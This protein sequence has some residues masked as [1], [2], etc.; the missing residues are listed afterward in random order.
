MWDYN[1]INTCMLAEWCAY[2]F[3]FNDEH[4]SCLQFI[5]IRRVDR[6]RCATLRYA[7][8]RCATLRYAALRCATLRAI[9]SLFRKREMTDDCGRDCIVFTAEVRCIELA[10]SVLCVNRHTDIDQCHCWRNLTYQQS[11]LMHNVGIF[12]ISHYDWTNQP[13]PKRRAREPMRFHVV[14]TW[15]V[16]SNISQHFENTV[17]IHSML[18]IFILSADQN[19]KSHWFP[20]SPFML[21]LIR[22][23]IMTNEE[24]PNVMHQCT[25]LVCQI[26]PTVT[27]IDISMVNRLPCGH[28]N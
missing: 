15:F 18:A 14:V 17:S 2:T 11:T 27:L 13:Q 9:I 1:W 6:A 19:V 3:A 12:L 4:N 23:A 20:G 5:C 16:K 10:L 24:N 7:A 22:P 26:S 21:R 25:L 28:I 8:L